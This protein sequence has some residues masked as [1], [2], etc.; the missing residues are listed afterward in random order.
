M[1]SRRYL[2][3]SISLVS[4]VYSLTPRT[5]IAAAIS[6]DNFLTKLKFIP[7]IGSCDCHVHIFDSRH[8]P[9]SDER[10]YTPDEATISDLKRHL[11]E[12]HMDRVV[13]IQPSPYGTDN[14]CMLNAIHILGQEKARG[15]AVVPDNISSTGLEA[16]H[17]QGIRGLRLNMETRSDGKLN[18]QDSA[19]YLIKMAK[20]IN[21]LGWHLQIY[22]N[23][24]EI[25]A[26][27]ET[28][29]NLNVPVVI[30]HMGKVDVKKGV[31]Q[32]EFKALLALLDSGNVYVKLSA[33]YRLTTDTSWK[34]IPS[35]IKKLVSCRADR[36]IWASDWPHTMPA[37]GKK[38]MKEGIEYFYPVDDVSILNAFG[39]WIDIEKL[40]VEIFVNNPTR[41]YWRN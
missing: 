13:L 21:H 38:R 15:V 33:L 7:P 31:Q 17:R 1:F 24:K 2:L 40:R 11:D 37:P 20:K 4:A 35:Y 36:L 28:I 25:I 39:D 8:Y 14:R 27:S 5:G 29:K 32:E 22:T 34:N 12:L 26:L 19:G 6:S 16:L 18:A 23:L 41:L 10:I 9:F 30:D 3:K